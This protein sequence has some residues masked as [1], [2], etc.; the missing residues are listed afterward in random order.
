MHSAGPSCD[1]LKFKF[2]AAVPLAMPVMLLYWHDRD[3]PPDIV[4]VTGKTVQF[5]PIRSNTYNIVENFSNSLFRYT[6]H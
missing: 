4:T 6:T 5:T 3:W 1:D 2:N